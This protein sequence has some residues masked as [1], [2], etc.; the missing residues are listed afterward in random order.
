MADDDEPMDAKDRV[1]Y[2]AQNEEDQLQKDPDWKDPTAS[3]PL[4]QTRTLDTTAG[5]IVTRKRGSEE[6]SPTAN[7]HGYGLRDRS[8]LKKA[9]QTPTI[10]GQTAERNSYRDRGMRTY[11]R[12]S[13][14]GGRIGRGSRSKVEEEWGG[15][16][17]VRAL[18]LDRF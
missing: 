9:E 16:N 7:R 11:G 18:I 6:W 2:L 17:T 14:K 15:W 13:G 8:K 3:A 1:L 12:R 5:D 10:L 4:G